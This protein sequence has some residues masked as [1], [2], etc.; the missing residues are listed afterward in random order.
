MHGAKRKLQGRTKRVGNGVSV[1]SARTVLSVLLASSFILHPSS[2]AKAAHPFITDDTG[3]QGKGNWQL[4]LQGD[5]LRDDRTA[6][7]VEQKNKLNTYTS[8]LS[9]GI[10]ENLDVQVGVSYLNTRTTANGVTL[11]D[12]SGMGDSTLDLKWRFYESDGFSL[13]LRPTLL[14][15]TGN[16]DKGLGTGKTSWGIALL[17]TY[18]AEPWTFLGNVAYT[19]ARF[20]LPQDA[21]ESRSDL[22]RVSGGASYALTGEVRLVGELG[23]RANESRNDAFLPDS[24]SQFGMLGVIYS[25]TKKID[26]D[27][28]FRKNFNRAE[29]DKAFLVGATFR[30]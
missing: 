29:F 17:A 9:Y 7:G 23:L 15:P 12:E 27:A 5:F 28:G 24:T 6:G 11:A 13:G 10:L 14:L 2:F 30:W 8:V 18:E 16:E 1:R 22:W 26:L 21:A 25:P 3:T 19:H 20:K 4:E